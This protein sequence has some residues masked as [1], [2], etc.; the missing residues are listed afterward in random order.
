MTLRDPFPDELNTPEFNAVWECIKDW[1]ISVPFDTDDEDRQLYSSATGN[2]VVAILDS[3]RKA[4]HKM[5]KTK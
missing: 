2:H 3:L 4:V 1:D 5:E